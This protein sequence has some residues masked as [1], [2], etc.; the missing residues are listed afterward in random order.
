MDAFW[1]DLLKPMKHKPHHEVHILINNSVNNDVNIFLKKI[2]ML[3]IS[4]KNFRMKKEN[5]NLRREE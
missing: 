4:P 3:N 5:Q 2:L 1:L